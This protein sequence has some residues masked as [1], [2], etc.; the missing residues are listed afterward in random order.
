LKSEVGKITG[1]HL[2]QEIYRETQALNNAN[3]DSNLKQLAVKIKKMGP[4]VHA[5]YVKKKKK[6]TEDEGIR[7][8]GSSS[9]N[10]LRVMK[11]IPLARDATANERDR[12][13]EV[14][15]DPRQNKVDTL[16][17]I[18][19]FAEV[20]YDEEDVEPNSSEDED[21]LNKAEEENIQINLPNEPYAVPYADV[22]DIIMPVLL[23]EDQE[24]SESEDDMMITID[25]EAEE[26]ARQE[27]DEAAGE[28]RI[29]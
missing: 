6:S 23:G 22:A 3:R 11:E 5:A 25:A 27:K 18:Q 21:E 10:T 26:L 15:P 7:V 28:A 12:A 24:G 1:R 19:K 13:M 29:K 17:F 2:Q 16:Q 8:S 4:E 9:G 20:H 14:S